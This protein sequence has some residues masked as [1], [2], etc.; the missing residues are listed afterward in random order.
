MDRNAGGIKRKIRNKIENIVQVKMLFILPKSI[1][2][3][4]NDLMK[5]EEK[6]VLLKKN[7][8]TV[9]NNRNGD[10]IDNIF[11][12]QEKYYRYLVKYYDDYCSLYI[13]S[14][15]N[16]YIIL[17]NDILINKNKIY[18]VDINHFIETIENDMKFTRHTLTGKIISI[19]V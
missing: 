19:K 10:N 12:K 11:S 6:L 2:L 8:K 4:H 3:M 13:E 15:F 16:F 5:T 14:R 17:V 1:I 18:T 9:K 7:I